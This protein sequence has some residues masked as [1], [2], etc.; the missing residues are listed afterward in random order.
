M[1]TMRSVLNNIG[2]PPFVFV[3]DWSGAR[4]A[5]FVRSVLAFGDVRTAVASAP[6]GRQAIRQVFYPKK[7]RLPSGRKIQTQSA[8]V[9]L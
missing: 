2:T 4:S 7:R 3:Y 9:V 1:A 5:V 8:D 6:C